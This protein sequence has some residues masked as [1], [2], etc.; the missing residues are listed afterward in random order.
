M[1]P[2]LDD[3]RVRSD[4]VGSRGS[5]GSRAS[6]HHAEVETPVMTPETSSVM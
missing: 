2:P 1:E 5:R 3:P 4:S 6:S